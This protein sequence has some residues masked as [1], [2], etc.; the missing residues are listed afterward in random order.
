MDLVFNQQQSDDL[1]PFHIK[2]NLDGAIVDCGKSIRK[3]CPLAVKDL[4]TNQFEIENFSN[5]PL[6]D[7]LLQH[8]HEKIVI[9]TKGDKV[10]HLTGQFLLNEQPKLLVFI[11]SPSFSSIKE[12]EENA[13]GRNDYAIQNAQIDLLQAL[14]LKKE[15]EE[16]KSDN[17]REK[18]I[19]CP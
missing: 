8:L 9:Q 18:I 17:L 7:Y 16:A 1:F 11:G 5:G 19:V 14:I 13:F 3:I 10:I 6:V 15:I 2:L 12:M 4:F